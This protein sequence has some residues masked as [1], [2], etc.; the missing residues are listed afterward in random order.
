MSDARIR[1]LLVDDHPVVREGLRTLLSE[2]ADID[3]VGEARNGEEAVRLARETRAD[4]VLLDLAMPGM[5]GIQAIRQI[6]EQSPATQIVALTS[7][8]DETRVRTAIEAGAVGYLLK[9]VLK[10]DLLRAIRNARLGQPSLHPQAQR[11]LMRRVRKAA[12]VSPLDVLTPRERTILELIGRGRNNKAIAEALGL[13]QGTVK[14][15]VSRILD[16]LGVQDRTQAALVAV[17][18]GLVPLS[19]DEGGAGGPL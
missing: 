12:E 16:K 7:F 15:H 3:C 5:D 4:V 1:L 10:E 19:K 18:E 17:R 8:S 2:E 6:R 11:H 9:D 14:G 13:T